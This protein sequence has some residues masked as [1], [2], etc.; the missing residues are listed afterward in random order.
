MVGQFW[1][2]GT[3]S[4]SIKGSLKDEELNKIFWRETFEKVGAKFAPE[5]ARWDGK[6]L[7]VGKD[8]DKKPKVLIKAID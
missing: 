5:L 2:C 8:K 3:H 4:R 6:K 1:V 7:I